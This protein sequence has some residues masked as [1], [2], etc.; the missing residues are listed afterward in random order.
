MYYT[1]IKKTDCNETFE[2]IRVNILKVSIL[3][4]K[5]ITKILPIAVF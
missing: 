3:R 2:E 5:I 4:Y 1:L